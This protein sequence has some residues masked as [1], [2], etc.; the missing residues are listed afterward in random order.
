MQHPAE[1]F[2]PPQA[3]VDALE[4]HLDMIASLM[5]PSA[6]GGV[7]VYALHLAV[8]P[9]GDNTSEGKGTFVGPLDLTNREAIYTTFAGH[10]PYLHDKIEET[11][12]GKLLV[13]TCEIATAGG[14]KDIHYAVMGAE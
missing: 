1:N 4:P 7:A 2:T 5:H 12:S 10:M 14:R 9:D 8:D 13:V 6:D 11:N 3:L